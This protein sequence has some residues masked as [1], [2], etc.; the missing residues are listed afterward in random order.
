MPEPLPLTYE[1]QELFKQI[2]SII[3]A[4]YLD[5]RKGDWVIAFSGGKDSTLVLD[6][7]LKVILSLPP[8]QRT[9]KIHVVSNNTRVES[10]PVIDHLYQ[11]HAL[12]ESFAEEQKLK[13]TCETTEPEDEESFWVNMIG[14]GYPPPSRIF[15]WCTEKLKINPTTRYIRKKVIHSGRVFLLLGTRSAES[16]SR[17]AS[18]KKHATIDHY[19]GQHPDFRNCLT[20]MPIRDL[21][22]EQVWKYLSN[23]T[24]PWGGSYGDLMAMYKDAH[25][26]ECPLVVDKSQLNQPSCGERSPR[27]GCWTCTLVK[28][29]RSLDG[30]ITAGHDYLIEYARFREWLIRFAA[31]LNNRLPYSRKGDV[32]TKKDG[33]ISPGPL[34]I[35]AR[36]TILAQLHQLEKTIGQRLITDEEI[37]EI[38][39]LWKRDESIYRLIGDETT[40]ILKERMLSGAA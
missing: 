33:T 34:S 5:K 32:R 20:F 29:D 37:E 14:K 15:R 10:P 22:D 23:A 17:A 18:I 19:F 24:P 11:M 31:D 25:G 38:E 27:F 3:R 2:S 8:H 9:R 40:A 21:T 26:G 36:K 12:I 39:K 7:V 1:D 13:I 4:A 6:L 35:E 16:A 28:K 30:M